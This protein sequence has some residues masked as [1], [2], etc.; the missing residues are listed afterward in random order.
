MSEIIDVWKTRLNGSG[1]GCVHDSLND[2]MDAVRG[3]TE[4]LHDDERLVVEIERSQ[5]TQ[6]D[7][8]ALPEFAG[9]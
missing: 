9:Y 5:M 6:A 1:G 7:Y 8:D 2:A 4:D 3:L